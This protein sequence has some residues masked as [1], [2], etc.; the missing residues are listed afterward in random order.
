MP[1][2]LWHWNAE[3]V[4]SRK[5]V[6]KHTH[7]SHTLSPASINNGVRRGDSTV[8]NVTWLKKYELEVC[9]AEGN[10]RDVGGIYIFTGLNA[11][12]LWRP[13]YIGQANSFRDRIPNHE[14]WSAAVRL[15]AT[16]VHALVVS[17]APC[18]CD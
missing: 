15:G 13:F 2:E 7:L 12:N 18:G 5:C 17:Q 4:W 8:S 14:N 3:P 16:H 9:N 1:T 6:C 10:W 11:Q